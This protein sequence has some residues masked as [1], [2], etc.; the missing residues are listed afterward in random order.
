MIIFI[1]LESPEVC[2]NRIKERILK[3]EHLVPDEDVI[4]RYYRGKNNFWNKCRF[5]VDYWCL[6]ENTNSNFEEISAGIK[7]KYVISNES[8][9]KIFLKGFKE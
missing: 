3:G 5:M 1:F 7:D 2:I 4:R 6:I 9:F 8:M